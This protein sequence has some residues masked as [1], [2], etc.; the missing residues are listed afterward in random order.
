[1]KSVKSLLSVVCFVLM[2]GF[3]MAGDVIGAKN[4]ESVQIKSYLNRIAFNQY[5]S[6]ETKLSISFFINSRHEIIVVSTSNPDLDDVVKTTLNYE[7]IVV[8]NLEYN[9]LYTIPVDVRL[10]N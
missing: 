3:V 4:S 2:S 5:I 10:L 1:M 8:K 6:S 9:K 7:K